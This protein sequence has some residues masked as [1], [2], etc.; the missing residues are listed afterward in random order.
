MLF[1][2]DAAKAYGPQTVLDAVSL[3]IGDGQH[4][5]LVGANGCGKSTLLRAI[6]GEEQLDDGAAGHRAGSLGFLQQETGL[7]SDSALRDEMWTAFPEARAIEQRLED[8]AAAIERGSG[9]LDDL[10]E[11]QARL[12]GEFEA[13]DGYRIDKR[14]GQVLHGLGFDAADGARRC[15]E[16][17]GGWRMRVALAKVL[18]RRPDHMLLDEPTNHL[19]AAARD[20]LVE[21]LQ[22]F[23]GTLLV[24]AHD[25]EFLDRVAARVIELRQGRLEFYS[26]N[27]SAF[28]SQK[29]ERI[30]AQGQAAARQQ[31]EIARQQRFVDRFR[32]TATKASAVKSRERALDRIDRIEAPQAERE[33]R[34]S[35]KSSGRTEL[36]VLSVQS[37]SHVYEVEPVLLDVNLEV[38]RG[39]KLLLVGPNGG[40]KSTLLRLLA[41]HLDPVEGSIGWAE[42]AQIAYYD[43]HQDA[44]L[45]ARATALDEVRSAAP[46]ESESALRGAL[47]RFG[48]SGDDALK[49]ISVLSGGE[50]SRVA[51]AKFL[52]QPSNVLL[53][54]EPTNHLDRPTRRQ[55]IGALADYDGTL[56]CASHDVGLR[57]RVATRV[58]EIDAG[59]CREAP[60]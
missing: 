35:L 40:G 12:F 43:Q 32:A 52:L 49:R 20:W 2:D 47:G 10:I 36:Q 31:R 48:L 51:L 21:D 13:L 45:D 25:R 7:D 37:L 6:A 1:A 34:F 56:L 9:E 50:R 46:R 58:L 38:E 19:D 24:V 44:A 26:G 29:A 54:D 60:P 59:E 17:S 30:H 57:E 15:S 18:V 55:L 14:I 16:F 39:E 23:S 53:L 41:G 33:I 11:Q 42:R 4:V 8:V 27:Y 5:A 28:Q 3:V 22:K